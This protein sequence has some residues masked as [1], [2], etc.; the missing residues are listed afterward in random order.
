MGKRNIRNI[1]SCQCLH[2]VDKLRGANI[3]TF[4]IF[5]KAI[6]TQGPELSLSGAFNRISRSSRGKI[7]LSNCI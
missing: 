2:Q 1:Q 5:D 3:V 6:F 7:I 4:I